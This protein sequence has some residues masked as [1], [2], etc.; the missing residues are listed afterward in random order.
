MNNLLVIFMII[1]V[2]IGVVM[3]FGFWDYILIDDKRIIFFFQFFGDLFLNM[4]KMLIFFLIVFS[5]VS[6]MFGL[7]VQVLGKMGLWIVLYYL[8]IIFCVV[9]FGIILVVVIQLGYKREVFIERSGGDQKF[10]EGLV[11]FLDL[12]R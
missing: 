1:V 9:V 7:K 10:V 8:I 11:L 6:V 3:G 12:I 4:L 5:F 2:I